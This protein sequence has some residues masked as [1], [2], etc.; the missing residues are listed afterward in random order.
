M[1][2]RQLGIA[3]AWEV[4]PQLHGDNRGVFLEWYRS[5]RLAD[6]VGGDAVGGDAV[7]GD[8]VGGPFRLAQANMS[9]SAR[10]VVRGIH[11]ADVPPGQAKYVTCVRGAVADV[12]VDL[13]VGSPTFGHWELVRLDEEQRRAV[14]LIEGL[15]HGFCALTEDATLA[16]LCSTTYNPAAER[17]VHPLDAD[18]AIDWPAGVPVLSARDAAAPSLATARAEGL[19]PQAA[20]CRAYLAE[21]DRERERDRSA[22]AA[23]AGIPPGMRHP[24]GIWAGDVRNA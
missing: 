3:G 1:R 12:V 7:G 11:Y 14:F 5:D 19:L 17:A 9:V 10:D 23:P 16:Y 21:R 18:L 8:A 13:R 4:I 24:D 20:T 6:A 22:A 2:I 15:G